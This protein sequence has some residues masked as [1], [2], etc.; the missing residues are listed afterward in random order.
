MT[1]P[2][3]PILS[4]RGLVKNFGHVQALRGVD[5]DVYPEEI[6]GLIGDNGAGKSTLVK[7]LSGLI[8]PDEGEIQIDGN[9]VTLPTPVAARQ[10]G[11]ETIY[12]DLALAPDLD[13][14][15]NLYLG[16][17]IP[18]R[19]LL[20]RMGVLDRP[21]MRA[22]AQRHFDAL[23]VS[24]K[25]PGKPVA[26]YSG[27]Q[28]QGVAVSRAVAWASRILFMDEPTAALARVQSDNVLDLMRRVRE[29]GLSVVMISH[30][31]P[32]VLQVT[33]RIEVLRLGQRVATL[34]SAD[35]SVEEL[36]AAMTGLRV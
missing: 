11:L 36:V 26:T 17:E 21:T 33:D 7:T 25:D 28:K 5:L 6:V 19:G 18:R 22:Q 31:L 9:P 29:R 14:V 32:E 3:T 10:A 34:R 1:N 20:G 16:R 24:I 23:G 2:A 4:V 13:A 12:Q 30:N 8:S 35:T 15:A 27:G